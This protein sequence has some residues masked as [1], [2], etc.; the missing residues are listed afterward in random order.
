MAR[1][2]KDI[3][4]LKKSLD[5]KDAE[6]TAARQQIAALQHKRARRI[7]LDFADVLG[8]TEDAMSKSEEPPTLMKAILGKLNGEPNSIERLAFEADPSAGDQY[9]GIYKQKVRLLPDAVLKRIAIQDDLVAC[10]VQARS[11]QV[12]VF[13]RPRDDRFTPG[14]VIEPTKAQIQ[15]MSVQEKEELQGRIGEAIKR[16]ASC[17]SEE[18][19]RKEERMSFSEWLYA[20]TRNA[21]VVGRLATEMVY[22][23]D[24]VTGQPVFH[25]FRPIDAG[26]IYRAVPH[27]Q[28]AQS[29]R[30]QSRGLLEQLRNEKLDPERFLDDEYAWIQ[31]IEGKPVQAFTEDEC[32][33]KNFYPVL[34][35]EMNGYPVTPLDTM[36]TQVT[37]HINI[38]SH[39]KLYFQSGRATRGML[40]IKSDDVDEHM[41]T[42]IKQQFQAS[43][44]SVNNAWRMPVFGVGS[45]D[46]VTWQPIDSGQRDMEFQYLSDMN[47]R[48]ILSAFQMS[49]EEL[50]G[51]AYLS[52]GTNNQALSES[53][54]E[55]RLEAHRDLG[56][57][58]LIKQF[59]D[60]LNSDIM[61]LI[62]EELSKICVLKLVGL[63]AETAE[64]ESVRIQQDMAV[65]MTYNEVLSRVEKKPI[66]AKVAGDFPLNPQLQSQM[67]KYVPVGTILETFFGIQ[68][69]AQDPQWQYVRDPFWFQQQERMMQQQQMQAQQQQAAQQGPG[70]PQ[71]GGQGGGDPGQGGG[72]E[73][74][75]GAPPEASQGQPGD[76]APQGAAQASNTGDQDPV[77]NDQAAAGGQDQ[78]GDLT[79]SIDQ[80]LGLLSKSEAQLP[81]GKR[82]LLGRQRRMLQSLV[83][84]LEMDLRMA[85]TELLNEVEKF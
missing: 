82:K 84:D 56:I 26:T 17:G 59:E 74:G 21:L 71:G 39:N 35:W 75:S 5:T 20:A 64:K 34:D 70:G 16:M 22:R 38:T 32:L 54:N 41:V 57:R 61:P 31:V 58:P 72:G 3:S 65:H 6:L 42:Q 76:Q 85:T 53:N 47:A 49:P 8:V 55:Y 4:N 68:G 40:L 43:I 60:F 25:G 2:T 23:I 10:I 79:R 51:W 45:D 48:A 27:S 7:N 77:Q 81:V 44:N 15:K 62:D 29:V 36:I 63:D 11:N 33:V 28:A 50:P 52:R 18:G 80:A 9:Q 12:S 66:P 46:E 14:F 19:W 30:E 24:E 13:G 83:K 67:D 69:A 78:G 37:T 73:D 1:P